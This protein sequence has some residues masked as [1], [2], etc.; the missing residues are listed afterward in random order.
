MQ[1]SSQHNLVDAQTG[2][3]HPFG[4][5]ATIP[6]SDPFRRLLPDA[7][8]TFQWFATIAERDRALEDMSARHRYSR[9]GDEP[10]V[11]YEPVDR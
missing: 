2:A 9:I 10:S 5:R 6:K 8:E 7:W 3:T 11:I 1:I 4:I